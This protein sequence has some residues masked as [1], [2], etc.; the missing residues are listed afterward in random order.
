MSQI[1]SL[2]LNES[3]SPSDPRD[4]HDRSFLGSEGEGYAWYESEFS[5]FEFPLSFEISF[6]LPF[7]LF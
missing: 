1:D 5:P 7:F 2:G 4:E 6:F 3:N